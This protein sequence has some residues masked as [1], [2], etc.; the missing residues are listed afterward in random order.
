MQNMRAAPRTARCAGSQGTGTAGQRGTSDKRTRGR[1]WIS[2]GH[3]ASVVSCAT[4]VKHGLSVTF[5]M[6]QMRGSS[7]AQL[8]SHTAEQ[9]GGLE[10]GYGGGGVP[11]SVRK[12]APVSIVNQSSVLG[13]CEG[14]AG[15][16]QP[17][18]CPE[19]P[20]CNPNLPAGVLRCHRAALEEL[21][22]AAGEVPLCSLRL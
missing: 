19:H 7:T 4:R 17:T 15:K 22:A 3:E 9:I 20:S 16:H 8:C 6:L 5:K 11:I 14:A 21:K 10:G 18:A 13:Q 2:F 12:K 1:L